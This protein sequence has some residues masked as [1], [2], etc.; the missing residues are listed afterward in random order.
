MQGRARRQDDQCHA[1]PAAQAQHLLAP[2]APDQLP[3]RAQQQRR[4]DDA[5]QIIPQR[6]HHTT[7]LI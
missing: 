2:L 3:R 5:Q 4:G 1:Q 7:T 6:L